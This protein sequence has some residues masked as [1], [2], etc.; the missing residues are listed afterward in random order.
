MTFD[1][2]SPSSMP[3]SCRASLR[4]GMMRCI[5]AAAEGYNGRAWG[6]F[7]RVG[8]TREPMERVGRGLR[9]EAEAGLEEADT[10]LRGIESEAEL[11]FAG[12]HQL[13]RPF[14]PS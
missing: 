1:L 2:L 12:L 13:C 6:I 8:P 5:G 3:L 11:A 4:P 14:R 7:H 9:R 10:K